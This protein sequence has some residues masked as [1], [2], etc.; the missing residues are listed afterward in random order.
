MSNTFPPYT[1]ENY[2]KLAAAIATG[3]QRVR[4]G[5]KE[6]E[7]QSTESMEKLLTTMARA[8]GYIKPGNG[9]TYAEFSR[10]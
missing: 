10:D 4:Y 1:Q 3:A 8:L 7:Y 5:T 2:D 6:I 9:R